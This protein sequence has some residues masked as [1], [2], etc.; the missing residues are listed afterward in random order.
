MTYEISECDK[1]I[2]QWNG[3]E[4]ERIFGIKIPN[5][6]DLLSEKEYDYLKSY[7]YKSHFWEKIGIIHLMSFKH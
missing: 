5:L 6:K 3:Y 7:I 4:L 1:T 2:S